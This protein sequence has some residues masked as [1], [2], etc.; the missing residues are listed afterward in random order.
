M[1][2]EF[3]TVRANVGTSF[4]FRAKQYSIVW[5]DHVFFLHSFVDGCLDC[6]Q[7]FALVNSPPVTVS[8]QI[9]I[10]KTQLLIVLDLYPIVQFHILSF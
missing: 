7:L 4:L 2:S 3:I 6:F 9:H 8:V 1:S 10:F 5:M